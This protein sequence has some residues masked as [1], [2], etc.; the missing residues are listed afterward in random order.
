MNEGEE[1][2]TLSLLKKRIEQSELMSVA[3]LR[4]HRKLVVR[5]LRRERQIPV[6]NLDARNE[7]TNLIQAPRVLDRFRTV[8]TD[9]QVSGSSFWTRLMGS[10]NQYTCITSPMTNR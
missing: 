6:F 2:Y 4:L 7:G 5:K 9:N 10:T 1:A 8:T 3:E